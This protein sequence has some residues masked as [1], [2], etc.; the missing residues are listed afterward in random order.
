MRLLRERAAQ[1]DQLMAT[2]SFPIGS[3]HSLT[4]RRVLALGTLIVSVAAC[5]TEAT[6]PL[7]IV[8]AGDSLTYGLYASDERLGYRELVNAEMSH[9]RDVEQSRGGQT[10]NT[11][12]T[13]ADSIEVVSDTDVVVLAVGT[14]DMWKTDPDVFAAD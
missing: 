1:R 4:W 9:S 13:V 10:G 11:A 5:A 6:P 12:R 2:H 3:S 8:F 14:N 7:R